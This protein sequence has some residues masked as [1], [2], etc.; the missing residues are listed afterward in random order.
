MKRSVTVVDY[1]VGNLFSVQRAFEV[2]GATVE[3]ASDPRTIETAER[4]VLPGVGAFA[5]GMRGLSERSLIPALRG[6]GTSGRPML[7][8]CLGMQML[9]DFS[10][11]FGRHEGLGLV[12]GKVV[13]VP[14]QGL[15]GS[16]GKIPHVGWTRLHRPLNR[17]DWSQGIL[18][19]VPVESAVYLT[20]SYMLVPD[21]PQHRLA[22]CFYNGQRIAAAV[23]AGR[24]FGCQFHPEKSGPVGLSIIERFMRIGSSL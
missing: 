23:Q 5:D 3:F 7:G 1:G 18:D 8:I 24:I 17:V 4:L 15:D 14:A 20:H 12:P 2:Q 11:E 21:D 19:G 9:A 6:Y 13:A 22:D 16:L 10:E